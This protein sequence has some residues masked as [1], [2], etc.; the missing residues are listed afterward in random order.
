M[1]HAFCIIAFNDYEQ[2]IKMLKILDSEI[3]DFY[4]HINALA[5]M[6][7]CNKIK[8]EIHKSGVYFTKRL[9][10]VWGENGV[11]N[12]QLVLLETALE[13]GGY[14]YYHLLSG[15]D[16]PL[17]SLA[18]LDSFLQSNLY[19]NSSESLYTN[20]ID[21]RVSPDRAARER[22]IHYNWLIKYWRHSKK[23]VRGAIR[24]INLISHGVQRLMHV[25]RLKLSP[26][27]IYYGSLWHSLTEACVTFMIGNK[28]WFA[29]N[30]SK[31][32]FAPDEGAVQTLLMNSE[33]R[34]SI[35]VPGQE[36]PDVN[37]RLAD[38]VRGS[39]ASPYVFR[40]RDF[41]ELV[42]SRDFFAR[43]FSESV[44]EEIV[45]KL[46]EYVKREV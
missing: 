34:D 37:L 44:D 8:S 19:N 41:E 9:P 7:D 32:S 30:F 17:K 38:Y 40:V 35:Y 1:R 14:D 26:D 43:K 12:A 23:A 27:K 6:P 5:E 28:E 15:Q 24:G 25:N 16:F 22:L 42:N 21:A 3:S 10:I 11:L 2:L 36:S 39:G 33:F 20:Y 13:H 4:I 18:A 29:K 46:Y 45:D 31:H